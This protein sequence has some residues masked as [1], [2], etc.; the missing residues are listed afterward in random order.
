MLKQYLLLYNT[1]YSLPKKLLIEILTERITLVFNYILKKKTSWI[2]RVIGLQDIKRCR[3][4][5]F[6]TAQFKKCSL[7]F[8]AYL[9][10]YSQNVGVSVG[11]DPALF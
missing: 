8:S 3:Q 4:K 6:H 9:L 11:I 10:L 5:I 1:L 2:F 7:S